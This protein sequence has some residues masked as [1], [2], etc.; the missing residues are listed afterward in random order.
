MNDEASEVVLVVVERL[1]EALEF[2][3]GSVVFVTALTED[4]DLRPVVLFPR[5][6]DEAST[7]L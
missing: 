4:A 5:A 1:C 7:A 2:V 6:V 3:G